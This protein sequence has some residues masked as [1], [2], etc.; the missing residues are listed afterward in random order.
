MGAIHQALLA[1]AIA[2]GPPTGPPT[3]DLVLWLKADAEAYNDAGTTLATDGQTVLQWNDQS[4]NGNNASES[5]PADRP[6]FETNEINGLPA[7]RFTPTGEQL[8]VQDVPDLSL[9]TDMSAFLVIKQTGFNTINSMISKAQGGNPAAFLYYTGIDGK[10][11]VDRPFIEGGVAGTTGVGDGVPC[12]VGVVINGTTVSHF[13]NGVANGTDTLTTG[14]DVPAAFGIGVM[15]GLGN[16]WTGYI[17]E[18]LVYKS[19]VDSTT[20]DEATAYLGGRWG[21]SV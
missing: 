1:V 20:R 12:I 16:N 3:T 21:I 15:T 2:G 8:L 18:I 6:F 13:L 14:T 17:G 5:T 11:A 10:P 7:L 9:N 4:G 19:A